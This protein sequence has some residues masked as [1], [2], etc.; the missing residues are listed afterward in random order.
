[1]RVILQPVA[2]VKET[3]ARALQSCRGSARKWAFIHSARLP[4]PL[5]VRLNGGMAA[6]GF[7]DTVLAM[8]S[9]LLL[10]LVAAALSACSSTT[11][12]NGS[13]SDGA[14]GGEGV[15][16]GGMTNTGGVGAGDTTAGDGSVSQGGAASASVTDS[17]GTDGTDSSTWSGGSSEITGSGTISG[18][19]GGSSGTGDSTSSVGGS[20]GT[21]GST[22]SVGGSSGTGGSMTTCSGEQILCDD[23]CIAPLSD[24][25]YCGATSSCTG[26][27]RGDSC[28]SDEACEAGVCRLQ[29]PGVQIPCDGT[30]I[31]PATD[32]AYCGA[33]NYCEDSDAGDVCGT[34]EQCLTGLCRRPDGAACN[35][36][37]ECISGICST[38]FLDIDG[39]GYG[40]E[41]SGMQSVCG[42]Q[43]PTADYVTNDL[44]CCD[45]A[46][47]LTLAAEANP[48]FG[49]NEYDQLG[50]SFGVPEC[51]KPFDWDCD[52]VE[53]EELTGGGCSQ[54]TTE[55]S[56]DGTF[57]GASPAC[58]VEADFAECIWTTDNECVT[59][60][61]GPMRQRCY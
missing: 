32:E 56:C 46:T 14:A 44:D 19:V 26:D 57:T 48:D 31:D 41:S 49:P 58:G 53:T 18:S 22:A 17:G 61:G 15:S 16:S 40:A 52:G 11:R 38:F 27:D 6:R 59:G 54:H 20:S 2:A 25:T 34:G 45:D 42:L 4:S 60:P 47:D 5:L 12:S 50:R 23:T 51:T 36:G 7:S 1:M 37:V 55:A 9:R 10:A 8:A 28:T 39:D 33:S 13:S 29:C 43:Q 3:V 24:D 30:C 21:G 35:V